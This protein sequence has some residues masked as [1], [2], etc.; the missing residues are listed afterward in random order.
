VVAASNAYGDPTK[1]N[2][3]SVGFANSLPKGCEG[4]AACTQ[5][6][7][8]GTDTGIAPNVKVTFLNSVSGKS[9]DQA[10]AHEGSHTADDLQF[11]NS[12]ATG[13]FNGAFNFVHYDTEFKAYAI[14]ASVRSGE[15][16]QLGT[17]G[18]SPCTFGP[19]DS[20]QGTYQK[21]D[22]MLTDPQSSYK[23]DLE[24]LQFDTTFYPQ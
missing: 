16:Y 5:A 2:G 24:K 9:L 10:V 20:I 18:G 6:G 4:G 3:L 1:D 19:N 8:K 15:A 17:C 13:K 23:N 14:G 22:Q 7:I 12:F 21:I 11:I